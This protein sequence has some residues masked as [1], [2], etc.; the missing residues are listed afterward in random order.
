MEFE[1][2]PSSNL[3]FVRPLFLCRSPPA[4]PLDFNQMPKSKTQKENANVKTGAGSKAAKK[5]PTQL[6]SSEVDDE[7]AEGIISLSVYYANDVDELLC[8]P[9][10]RTMQTIWTT[11]VSTIALCRLS[12]PFVYLRPIFRRH[13]T[14]LSLF[15][16]TLMRHETIQRVPLVFRHAWHR[17]LH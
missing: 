5:K 16:P 2:R 15:P 11:R 12:I 10:P 14:I 13:F 4:T 9:L 17:L 3:K 7:G 1:L 6:L 8:F